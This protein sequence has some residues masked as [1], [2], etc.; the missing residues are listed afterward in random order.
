ML[1]D[2]PW[3]VDTM[4]DNATLKTDVIFP[5]H[6]T[7]RVTTPFTGTS[8]PSRW[9]PAVLVWPTQ[10]SPRSDTGLFPTHLWPLLT[11][12]VLLRQ[13]QTAWDSYSNHI[14]AVRLPLGLPS[15]LPLTGRLWAREKAAWDVTREIGIPVG[16]DK[17]LGFNLA[18]RNSYRRV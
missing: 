1:S 10:S 15:C 13:P 7:D 17:G 8:S 14:L 11:S 18:A 16:Q 4:L 5:D 12:H 3:L 6:R 2:H 9:S